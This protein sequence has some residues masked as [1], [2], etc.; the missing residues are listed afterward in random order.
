[1]GDLLAAGKPGYC[2]YLFQEYI[3]DVEKVLKDV[4]VMER[5]T[6]SAITGA[7]ALLFEL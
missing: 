5:D 4:W 3:C 1:M 6:G 7:R 2:L